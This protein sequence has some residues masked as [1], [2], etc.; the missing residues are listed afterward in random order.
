MFYIFSATDRCFRK[1]HYTDIIEL[2]YSTLCITIRKLGSVPE[3]IC[4]VS[5]FNS[6]LK[7]TSKFIYLTFPCTIDVILL[8]PESLGNGSGDKKEFTLNNLNDI[9]DI[10]YKKRTLDFVTDFIELGYID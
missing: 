10:E 7:H 8:D 9:S 5:D 3:K 1:Q 6:L 2:Y 4:S